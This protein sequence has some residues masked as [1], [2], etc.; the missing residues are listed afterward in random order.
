MF[1]KLVNVSPAASLQSWRHRNRCFDL[2]AAGRLVGKKRCRTTGAAVSISSGSSPP[3]MM[4]SPAS[5]VRSSISGLPMRFS[6]FLKKFTASGAAGSVG[7]TS[8]SVCHYHCDTVSVTIPIHILEIS[9][10]QGIAVRSAVIVLAAIEH[11][12]ALPS[13]RRY[14]ALAFPS[15]KSKHNPPPGCHRCQARPRSCLTRRRR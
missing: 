15:V 6:M 9:K 10:R 8:S 12:R 11:A 4:L 5:P 13:D 1:S 14:S 3:S 7:Y 2:T